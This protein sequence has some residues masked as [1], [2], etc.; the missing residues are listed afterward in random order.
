MKLIDVINCYVT[1]Q[2][3]LGMSF[4]SA[5]RI[6][7]RFS[8]NIGDVR[9]DQIR[10]QAV[11][12]FPQGAAP[13]SATWTLKYRVLSGFY[14]FAISRGYVGSSPLPQAPQSCRRRRRPM[15]TLPTNSVG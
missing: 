14:R 2:Q 7:R 12:E 15:C 1:L 9:I 6:L 10:P 8:R 4:G 13:L 11:A 5:S 3:S